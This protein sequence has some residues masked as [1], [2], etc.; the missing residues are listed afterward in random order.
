MVLKRVSDAIRDDDTIRAVIR[1]TAS[2]QDGKSPGITQPTKTAQVDLIRQAYESAGLDF[3]STRYFEAH[4]TGTP[5][6]DPIEASAISSVF[7]KYRSPEDPIYIGALKS[8]IGHLEGAAGIAGL[9][10]SVFVLERGI[11]PPNCWF[12]KPNPKIYAEEWNFKF[13]TTSAVWPNR[14]LRRASINAFGYGGS[15][16]HVVMEDALSYLTMHN[17]EGR[18]RTVDIPKLDLQLMRDLTPKPDDSMNEA[19]NPIGSTNPAPKVVE[20]IAATDVLDGLADSTTMDGAPHTRAHIA[21]KPANGTNGEYE[22]NGNS[23]ML[24]NAG[25][26]SLPAFQQNNSC[27]GINVD[28][29]ER[30]FVLSSFDEAGVQRLAQAYRNH[31]LSKSLKLEN[32]DTYLDDLNYTLAC[33]RTSFVWRTS[34]IASSISSLAQA[35]ESHPKPVRSGSN[36]RIG[37]VFTGQGAQWY[38]MGRGLLEYPVFRQS[39]VDAGLYLLQLRCPWNLMG[40]TCP[41]IQAWVECLLTV[42]RRVPE[43]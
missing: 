6:G 13:P 18:H 16:A 41:S 40:K 12:E 3:A 38:A 25:N 39:L 15:N 9:L 34:I 19:Q 30:I 35:L 27:V 14:G 5:V 8:N 26:S 11:I 36:A 17:R 10:K 23:R 42:L 24:E 22:P 37:F 32:E 31:L 43:G 21:K 2:N 7:T 4:G 33:K 20:I 29:K 1:S 28:C